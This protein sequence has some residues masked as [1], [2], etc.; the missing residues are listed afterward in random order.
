MCH[1]YR[2]GNL[3]N[4]V[5]DIKSHKWFRDTDWLAVYNCQIQPP[6]VPQIK[7]VGDSANFDVSTE[8]NKL[9]VS[10]HM[11]YNEEFENF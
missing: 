7:S 4:G 6:F 11:W 8:E 9:R 3:R 1:F 5:Q 2:Y 10:E